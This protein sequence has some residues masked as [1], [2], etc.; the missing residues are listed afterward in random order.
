MT[1]YYLFNFNNENGFDEVT[2]AEFFAFAGDETHRPYA[3][4]VYSGKILIE[5]V[6]E[7]YRAT[8][9]TIVANR[10]IRLGQYKEADIYI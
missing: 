2:Q 6:P 1:R 5:D 7:E 3:D 8:V 9:A 4:K 10:T